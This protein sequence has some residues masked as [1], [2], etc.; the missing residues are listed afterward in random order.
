DNWL[1]DIE[2]GGS[3]FFNMASFLSAG[4]RDT[5]HSYRPNWL[6]FNSDNYPARGG[7]SD[8]PMKSSGNETKRLLEESKILPHTAPP[9]HGYVTTKSSKLKFGPFSYT[10]RKVCLKSSENSSFLRISFI[11][12]DAL[13]VRHPLKKWLP[14]FGH[15]FK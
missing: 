2:Y 1:T 7:F 13:F 3:S 10:L 6:N 5:I 15:D 4:I 8:A 14:I 11:E 9:P 12:A